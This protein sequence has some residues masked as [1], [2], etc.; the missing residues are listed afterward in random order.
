MTYGLVLD[1]RLN[2]ENLTIWIETLE[3]KESK[4]L[5]PPPVEAKDSPAPEP[6]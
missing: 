1:K 2:P 5:H 6:Y 4:V 3:D